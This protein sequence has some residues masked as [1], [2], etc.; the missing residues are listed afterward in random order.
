MKPHKSF[1]KRVLKQ[2]VGLFDYLKLHNTKQANTAWLKEKETSHFALPA[3]YQPFSLIPSLI[4]K[5]VPAT[6][7]RNEQAHCNVSCDGISLTL[8]AGIM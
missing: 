2:K 1:K 6:T 3:P 7:N 4:W 8:L 5:A